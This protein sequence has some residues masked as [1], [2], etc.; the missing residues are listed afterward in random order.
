MLINVTWDDSRS[1]NYMTTRQAD[2]HRETRRLN[3]Y[4][5]SRLQVCKSCCTRRNKHHTFVSDMPQVP[6]QA[7]IYGPT[8][9]LCFAVCIQYGLSTFHLYLYHLQY[10]IL[11]R[12][13]THRPPLVDASSSC[14]QLKQLLIISP[15]RSKYLNFCF[16][17]PSSSNW[18]HRD[19]PKR[20]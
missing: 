14:W 15:F 17:D 8:K 5:C 4:F 12:K 6:L 19:R 9:I 7:L 3:F 1:I 10:F 20:Y 18:V 13:L 2:R 16:D 11:S